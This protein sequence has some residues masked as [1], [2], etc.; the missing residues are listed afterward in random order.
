MCLSSTEHLRINEEE[1]ALMDGYLVKFP[2]RLEVN[3]ALCWG[4]ATR[5]L[6]FRALLYFF[7]MM[8]MISLKMI[9]I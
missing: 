4:L 8:L 3:S 7:Q 6:T 9:T 1:Q 5:N 2:R